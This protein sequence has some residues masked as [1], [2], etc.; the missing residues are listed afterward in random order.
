[1]SRLRP[2]LLC[3]AVLVGASAIAACEPTLRQETGLV[4]DV[5]QSSLTAV[6]GF[7]LRTADDRTVEFSTRTTRFDVAFPV[8]HLREHLA[9][10]QPITV[11]YKLV[12]GR[13][14][15]VKLADAEQR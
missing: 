7:R 9:L 11:T 8:Q 1:M 10:A 13:N 12:E 3:L 2:L 15:V 14:E 5:Q 6:D 4:V